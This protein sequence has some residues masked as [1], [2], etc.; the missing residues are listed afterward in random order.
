MCQLL[1]KLTA[2]W[3]AAGAAPAWAAVVF[4][5]LGRQEQVDALKAIFKANRIYADDPLRIDMSQP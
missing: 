1:S 5:W 4:P 3:P 2:S